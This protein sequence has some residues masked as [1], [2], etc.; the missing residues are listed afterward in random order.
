MRLQLDTI[1]SLTNLA[2]TLLLSGIAFDV[3][4]RVTFKVPRK[5][6]LWWDT[7]KPKPKLQ[8]AQISLDSKYEILKWFQV[9]LR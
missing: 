5:E 3:T 6:A 8:A 4:T 9:G 2:S 7:L 1:T